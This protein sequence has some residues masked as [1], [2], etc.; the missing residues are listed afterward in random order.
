MLF[1]S[2]EPG[3][4]EAISDK[5]SPDLP[6]AIDPPVLFEAPQNLWVQRLVPARTIR[7]PDRIDWTGCQ[8]DPCWP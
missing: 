3:G 1:I 8:R 5:L 7:E 2:R 6:D 4:I